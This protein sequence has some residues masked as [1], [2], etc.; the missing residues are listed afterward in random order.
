MAE[1]QDWLAEKGAPKIQLMVRVDNDRALNFYEALGL[2][3]QN[4]VT[5]GQ[6][7]DIDQQR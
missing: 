3:R 4:V 5:F 1:A 2:D 7:L 6:F